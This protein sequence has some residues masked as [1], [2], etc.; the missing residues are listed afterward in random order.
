MD[1][2][3]VAGAAIGARTG[4]AQIGVAAKMMKMNAQQ[5]ADI[6]KLVEAAAEN[7][8]RLANVAAGVGRALDITV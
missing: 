3:A 7:G 8:Q 5:E 2:T 6:A 4:E 1:T